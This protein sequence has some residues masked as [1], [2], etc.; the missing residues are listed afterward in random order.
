MK[1]TL[2]QMILFNRVT[3]LPISLYSETFEL[4]Q[5]IDLPD[6][7]M[8]TFAKVDLPTVVNDMTNTYET[9]RTLRHEHFL[10]YRVNTDTKNKHYFLVIGPFKHFPYSSVVID[11][12]MKE[13]HLSQ[14]ISK[15]HLFQYYYSLQF[16]NVSYELIDT[17]IT[18]KTMLEYMEIDF[19]HHNYFQEQRLMKNI[20][21]SNNFQLSD[22]REF[23][24]DLG[25]VTEDH[26]RNAKNIFIITIGTL[27]RL[28]IENGLD[29]HES[30]TIGDAYMRKVENCTNISELPIYFHDL[31]R[32]FQ[33]ALNTSKQ[34]NYSRPIY[35]ALHYIEN[36]LS[37]KF[38]LSDVAEYVG[39]HRTYLSK[40]FKSEMKINFADHVLNRRIDEAKFYL[41][42]SNYTL[43]EISD[44]LA[45]SS[46][47]YFYKC[48]K[49]H[50]KATP[51]EYRN[52]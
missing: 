24:S 33:N 28:A 31:A 46:K 17:D 39:L 9:H 19:Y 48:F 49:K 26:I 10:I 40:L 7:P 29:A 5:T 36:N 35:K 47:S 20:F 18:K 4:L 50:T 51:K 6:P 52:A 30:F 2:Q 23:E 38:T 21:R 16:S 12:I 34:K 1:N 25:T 43:T 45:F 13:Q 44:I 15:T 42:H 37:R 27:Q 32:K 3:G 22:F 11:T 41:K 14:T 8:D